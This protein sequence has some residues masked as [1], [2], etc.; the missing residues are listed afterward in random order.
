MGDI[1]A[2]IDGTTPDRSKAVH[3]SNPLDLKMSFIGALYYGSAAVREDKHWFAGPDLGGFRVPECVSMPL[4]FIMKAR[5]RLGQSGS[6]RITIAG[7]SRG[8]YSAIRV[9]QGSAKPVS[10]WSCS[11]CWTRSR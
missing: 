9:V 10:K 7:Y 1:F 4:E 11:S 2:G 8:A 3:F 6:H 5:K